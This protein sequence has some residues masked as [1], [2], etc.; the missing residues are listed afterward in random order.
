MTINLEK[1]LI[2]ANRKLITPEEL[3]TIKEY[4]KNANFLQDDTFARVGLAHNL[5]KGNA[6]KE[7]I[8]AYKAQ[9]QKFKQELVFHISQIEEVCKKYYL[10]FLPSVHYKGSIDKELKFKINTFE[11]AYEVKC[12][13]DYD[14]PGSHFETLIHTDDGVE[15]KVPYPITQNTFIVAPASSFQLEERPKDPLFFYKINEE[16]FYL[17]HKWGND[18]SITR[19]AMGILSD[20]VTCLFWRLTFSIFA[21]LACFTIGEITKF[22][23]IMGIINGAFVLLT[24]G[25]YINN[26][27]DD[28]L[29]KFALFNREKWTSKYID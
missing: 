2:K 17:I 6:A 13:C 1:E 18:L 21:C 11:A 16:Y 15:I 3:L 27:L 29:E 7:R 23:L 8:N 25:F 9:T 14:Y 22:D 28:E 20:P 4:E 24:M 19:R 26:W 10:R 12:Q 5:A